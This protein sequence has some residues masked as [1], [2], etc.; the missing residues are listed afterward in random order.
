V[1]ANIQSGA[2]PDFDPE[3]ATAFIQ[4]MRQW[5]RRVAVVDDKEPLPHMTPGGALPANL[6]EVVLLPPEDPAADEAPSGVTAPAP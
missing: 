1:L 6:P 3:L 5:E 2:G 4:M